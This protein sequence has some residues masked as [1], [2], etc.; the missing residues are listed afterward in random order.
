MSAG[1]ETKSIVRRTLG[2]VALTLFAAATAFAA[3]AKAEDITL[4]SWRQEDKAAYAKLITAFRKQHPDINVKFEAFEAA[5]YN[6]CLLYTS[7]AAD[8]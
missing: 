4:W 3:P 6:T 8:E 1:I 7:D 5:N 2:K